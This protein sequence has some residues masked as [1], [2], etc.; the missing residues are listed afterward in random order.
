MNRKIIETCVDDIEGYSDN[1]YNTDY[2][3]KI[4]NHETKPQ[5]IKD[6]TQDNFGEST[7]SANVIVKNYDGYGLHFS[8][9]SISHLPVI[10]EGCKILNLNYCRNINHLPQLPDSIENLFLD[11]TRISSIECLPK[12][13]RVIYLKETKYLTHIKAFP[14]S[15]EEIYLNRSSIKNLPTLPANLRILY[16]NDCKYLTGLPALPAKIKEIHAQA[17]R[18]K[19]IGPFPDSVTIINLNHSAIETVEN[20][21]N[22]LKKFYCTNTKIRDLPFIP[23]S[24]EFIDFGYETVYPPIPEHAICWSIDELCRKELSTQW[25]K[26]RIKRKNAI[27]EEELKITVLTKSAYCDLE[28]NLLGQ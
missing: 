9:M 23:E 3:S 20:L 12:N 10:P 8:Y 16:V 11:M 24:L 4:K 22:K 6:L 15:V 14:D 13:L 7:R 18:F 2:E 19:H 5:Y 21:P 1:E 25:I 28:Q 17:T 27:L 26:E